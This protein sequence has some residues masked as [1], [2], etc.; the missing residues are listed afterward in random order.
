MDI[1]CLKEPPPRICDIP[2][3]HHVQQGVTSCHHTSL[4]HPERWAHVYLAV[5]QL[6]VKLSMDEVAVGRP[7]IFQWDSGPSSHGLKDA[8]MVEEEHTF[9]M[10]PRDLALKFA[11]LES[12]GFLHL[13]QIERTSLWM[14]SQLG[15]L[16]QV[17]YHVVQHRPSSWWNRCCVSIIHHLNCVAEVGGGHIE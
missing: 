2:L 9:L 13:G 12:M 14:S 11:W 4:C 8:E 10:G 17:Q 6:K 15:G 16:P 1:G 5:L 7:Y 3:H